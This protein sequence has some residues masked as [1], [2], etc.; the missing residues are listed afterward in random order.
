M[1]EFLFTLKIRKKWQVY[2]KNFMPSRQFIGQHEVFVPG[3]S[4]IA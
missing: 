4:S 3:I 2:K 1:L